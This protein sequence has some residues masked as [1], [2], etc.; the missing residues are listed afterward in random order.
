MKVGIRKRSATKVITSL[1]FFIIAQ[2]AVFAG[3]HRE[4]KR[5]FKY[6]KL[7]QVLQQF[8]KKGY[9]V[10][11]PVQV[12]KV[13]KNQIW[14]YNAPSI[15]AEHIMIVNEK[16]KPVRLEGNTFVYV[17]RKKGHVILI[18]IEGS[19]NEDKNI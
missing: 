2:C 5:I 7:S 16:G 19:P 12:T 11:G 6:K 3:S 8:Q 14:F 9:D 17:I 13:R 10:I 4:I 1:I 18:K 15:K